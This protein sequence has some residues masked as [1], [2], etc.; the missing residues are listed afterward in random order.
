LKQVQFLSV[1]GDSDYQHGAAPALEP[2]DFNAPAAV[3][4]LNVASHQPVA[5]RRP[6]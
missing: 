3:K 6:A 1:R 5:K 2:T 4:C